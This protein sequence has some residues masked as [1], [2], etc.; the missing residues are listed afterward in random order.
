MV[1]KKKYILCVNT[2]KLS[3][4]STCY[5]RYLY[6]REC[7]LEKFNYHTRESAFL[8][9]MVPLSVSP[10]WFQLCLIGLLEFLFKISWEISEIFSICE[11]MKCKMMKIHSGNLNVLKIAT[12]IFLLTIFSFFLSLVAAEIVEQKKALNFFHFP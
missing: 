9:S 2:M 12:K 5:S 6:K 7:K 4:H 11:L 8:L 1:H 10:R 3:S